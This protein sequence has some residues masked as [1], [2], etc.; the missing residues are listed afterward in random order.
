MLFNSY[1]FLLGF[2]PVTLIGFFLIARAS[3]VFAAAWL[4]LASLVFY[5]WWDWRYVPILLAS[6]AFNFAVGRLIDRCRD[7]QGARRKALLVGAIVVDLGALAYFK[8]AEFL[9]SNVA[10]LTG[11]PLVIAKIALPLGISFYTFTQL[12]YLVDTYRKKATEKSFLHYVLFVTYFPHLIAGPIIHHKDVMP[13]FA[14]PDTYRFSRA[15][16]AV[17]AVF[18][19]VGLFKKC[20]LADGVAVFATPVFDA[21]EHGQVLPLLDAWGGALAYTC[22]LYFDF[23]GYSDMAVG[24]SLMLNV[25]LPFNFDSPYK[26]TS[27]SDFWRRWH[28]SLS[29]F[30]RDYLYIPLGGNRNGEFA[31]YRNLMLTMLIGGLWHGA[32]WTFVLWGG[33]HGAYLVVNHHWS[34]WR[35]RRAASVGRAEVLAGA[36]LTFLA[37][38][39]AW[40]FF[41]ATSW[42]GAVNLLAGMVGAGAA[43]AAPSVGLL[44]NWAWVVALLMIATLLPNTQ[45]FVARHV[46]DHPSIAVEAREV[47][48]VAWR[49]PGLALALGLGLLTA[50]SL[51]NL[52]RPSEFLY[53]NF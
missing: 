37:V 33:L 11:L 13:Q 39:V 32:G 40:V 5:G 15:G 2:L 44:A 34:A 27:I 14:R 12:A 17:G 45:E 38:V 6:I 9:V 24:L 36:V 47:R 46:S 7:G 26:A 28:I 53:F 35:A 48:T 18:L 1:V 50:L 52:S 30:L 19:I 43:P 8:Y 10:A 22:Q 31:R 42:Q 20:F 16:F 4:G 51:M 25:K 29:T 21:A 41:R 23:S 49:A 3:R